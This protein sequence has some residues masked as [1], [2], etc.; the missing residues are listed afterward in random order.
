MT[1]VIPFQCGVFDG[2]FAGARRFTDQPAA[3]I[4]QTVARIAFAS[5][6]P[7][8]GQ[9]N[10]SRMTRGREGTV[11]LGGLWR[12]IGGFKSYVALKTMLP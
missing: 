7:D 6:T 5:D 9:A 3:P 1:F 4:A 12:R 11:A 8:L 10:R 2:V